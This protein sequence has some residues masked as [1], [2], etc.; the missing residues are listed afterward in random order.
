M[1]GYM[2]VPNIGVT[3]EISHHEVEVREK[4]GRLRE[5]FDCTIIGVVVDI[6][7]K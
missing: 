6:Q 5:A 3:V 1:T 4:V 7:E 2:H